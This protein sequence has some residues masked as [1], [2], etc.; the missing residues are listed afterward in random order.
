MQKAVSFGF[1]SLSW[2]VVIQSTISIDNQY[3]II[4]YCIYALQMWE[5]EPLKQLI[6]D[7]SKRLTLKSY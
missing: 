2:T 3:Q 1:P 6:E 7:R 5:A 4:N